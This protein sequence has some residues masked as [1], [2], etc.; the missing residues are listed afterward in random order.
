VSG[1]G[2]PAEARLAGDRVVIWSVAVPEPLAIPRAWEH[3]T[4]TADLVTAEGL[5]LPHRRL[6]TP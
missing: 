2:I 1:A 3:S 6:M 5:A 4:G